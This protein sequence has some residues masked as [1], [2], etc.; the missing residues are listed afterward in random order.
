MQNACCPASFTVDQ[1]WPLHSQ[2][3]LCLGLI[4]IAITAPAVTTH[5]VYC[6]RTSHLGLQP[7]ST[8]SRHVYTCGRCNALYSLQLQWHVPERIREI[9]LSTIDAPRAPALPLL[10]RARKPGL[11]CL[12][13][14]QANMSPG[15]ELPTDKLIMTPHSSTSDISGV[16]PPS[17]SL[18]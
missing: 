15:Y 7:S 11:Y 1:I 2:A 3:H 8:K 12:M 4:S 14:Y 17:I 9:D 5:T 13:R 6:P 10:V 18:N 16:P